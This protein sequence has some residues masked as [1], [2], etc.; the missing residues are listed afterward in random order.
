MPSHKQ[1]PPIDPGSIPEKTETWDDKF[2]LTE[3][4]LRSWL[5][6]PFERQRA[7]LNEVK[8]RMRD[9]G[10]SEELIARSIHYESLPVENRKKETIKLVTNSKTGKLWDI[11]TLQNAG[12]LSDVEVEGIRTEHN[13]LLPPYYYMTNIR[14]V[15]D[16]RQNL[17]KE[18]LVYSLLFEGI[19]IGKR[20]G[21]INPEPNLRINDS[22][23]VGYH[24]VP[25]ITWET[26]KDKDGEEKGVATFDS[27]RTPIIDD[28]STRVYEL[29]W[30]KS[31]IEVL[32]KHTQNGQV[33]LGIDHLSKSKHYGV[34]DINDFLSDNIAEVIDRYEKP[35]PTNEYNFNINPDQLASFMKYQAEHNTDPQ[36]Q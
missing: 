28:V 26:V 9:E 31:L 25:R 34:K 32:L 7:I 8:Q 1:Q 22:A 19:C 5:L 17:P 30:D 14:R 33:A 4:N 13:G 23:T 29:Q 27:T 12:K 10:I 24:L 3:S 15:L 20:D 35:K 36:Y 21:H 11:P 6:G 2:E 18:Y 16:D